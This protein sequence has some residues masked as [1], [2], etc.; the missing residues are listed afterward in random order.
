MAKTTGHVPG[1]N[2]KRYRSKDHW[3]IVDPDS[4]R[5]WSYGRNACGPD[6]P[7]VEA[8]HASWPCTEAH[9]FQ[10][11]DDMRALANSGENLLDPDLAKRN[12]RALDKAAEHSS[13]SFPVL[14]VGLVDQSPWAF[15]NVTDMTPVTDEPEATEG[16]SFYVENSDGT[17]TTM[18][19]EQYAEYIAEQ[20]RHETYGG[21]PEA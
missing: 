2:T 20:H 8:E 10:H 18:N 21:V 16:I 7:T 3:I 6:G 13:R 14:I 12:Q 19:P 17:I 15:H 5:A 11:A 9:L 4:R 1:P